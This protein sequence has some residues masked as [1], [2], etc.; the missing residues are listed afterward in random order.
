MIRT[1]RMFAALGAAAIAWAA[2]P[3][4][5]QDQ[6]LGEIRYVPYSFCPRGFVEAKGQ[7]LPIQ[8]NTALFSLIGTIYGGDGRRNFAL[9]NLS[10]APMLVTQNQGGVSLKACIAVTGIFPARD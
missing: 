5:A 1:L 3:A 10:G 9:P 7:T 6:F 4:M 2:S 8:Q